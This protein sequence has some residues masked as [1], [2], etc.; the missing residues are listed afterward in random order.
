[1]AN[2]RGHYGN[3]RG[4]ARIG[5]APSTIYVE[6]AP[7][8]TLTWIFGALAVGGAVLWARQQSQQINKLSK[9]EHVPQP[10]FGESLRADVKA[11]P[12]RASETLHSLAEVVKP[13]KRS[14]T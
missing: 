11:L 12:A 8:S 5:Q 9:K 14:R 7:T 6:R 2:A 3:S 1:M 13:K 10:S 4:T